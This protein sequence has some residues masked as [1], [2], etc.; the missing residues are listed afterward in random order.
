MFLEN[1]CCPCNARQFQNEFDKWASGDRE[2]DKFIQQIQL[3]AK[4]YQEIIEWIPFDKLENVT[5]LAKGGF[6]TV[7]KAEWLD[8]FIK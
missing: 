4:I 3:N 6:G 8:G 2:I 7:Y 1:W 5:C